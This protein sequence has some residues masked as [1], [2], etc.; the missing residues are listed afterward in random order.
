MKKFFIL[1][2][3][4]FIPGLVHAQNLGLG[5]AANIGLHAGNFN[6]PQEIVVDIVKYLITFVAI[7]AVS[8][9]ILGGFKWMVSGGNSEAIIDARKLLL[10]GMIGLVIILTSYTLVEYV[11]EITNQ[12]LAGAM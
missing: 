8:I 6:N 1:V 11:V 9:I 5:Y 7:M 4:F 10:S 3:I 12:V 2:I